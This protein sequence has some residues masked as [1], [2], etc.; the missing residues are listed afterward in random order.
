MIIISLIVF[1]LITFYF[2]DFADLIPKK[3][4]ILTKVQ[5]VPALLSLSIGMLVFLLVITLLFGRIYCSA[6]CPMGILQD[7]FDWFAKKFNR[8]K[9]YPHRKNH[10]VLRWTIVGV[11]I[12]AFIAGANVLISILDPYSMYGRIVT[13]L[14]KP[15]YLFGNNIIAE[16]S[17]HYKNYNFYTVDILWRGTMAF[18]IAAS[19]ILIVGYLA[20]RYGRLYCNTIC[21]VGTVLGFIS[22]YS[23]F[24]IKIG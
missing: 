16:I 20:Y 3:V 24:K 1:A 12:V 14:F 10:P 8:K 19:S 4:N 21:P 2:L 7:F 15:V 6:I 13:H 23:F 9:K 17:N 11:L 22:K 5:F 18:T